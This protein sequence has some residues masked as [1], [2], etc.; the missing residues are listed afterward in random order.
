MGGMHQG[1]GDDLVL[2]VLKIAGSVSFLV[3]M[4]NNIYKIYKHI[5]LRKWS[6]V[7]SRSSQTKLMEAVY[8][9]VVEGWRFTNK[10]GRQECGLYQG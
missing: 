2:L 7:I 10:K 4:L 3:E 1:F 6:H 5:V 8:G 9:T